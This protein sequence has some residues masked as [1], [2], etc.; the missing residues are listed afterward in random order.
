LLA[1]K[2]KCGFLWVGITQFNVRSLGKSPADPHREDPANNPLTFFERLELISEALLDEGVKRG[3][4]GVIPFPIET[5]DLLPDFLP[6][7]IPILTTICEQW[8]LYKIERLEEKGYRV[9]VL[10]ERKE[11]QFNGIQVRNLIR[12][13][14]PRWRE[15]VPPATVRAVE[16]YHV[17]ERL[18][19]LTI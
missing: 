2:S 15:L 18:Q 7:S 11:K 16:R 8:N 10:W 1:A 14:D 9:V 13:G 4:F 12:E 5:P 6:T 19:R 17:R 3:E